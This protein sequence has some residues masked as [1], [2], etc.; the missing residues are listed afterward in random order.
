MVS[1]C[2]VGDTCVKG[3]VNAIRLD[4]SGVI[5]KHFLE[6]SIPGSVICR[7]CAGTGVD[8]KAVFNRVCRLCAG[9]GFYRNKTCKSCHCLYSVEGPWH[10]PTCIH[11]AP[12]QVTWSVLAHEDCCDACGAKPC[13]VGPHHDTRCFRHLG[14]LPVVLP[15][16][17]LDMPYRNC[18]SCYA[19]PI[20]NGPWH[21]KDCPK[22][23]T[24]TDT[25]L[26]EKQGDWSAC[27]FCPA[28][29]NVPG[30]HHANHDQNRCP[31]FVPISCPECLAKPPAS[32]PHHVQS[33][34]S[35]CGTLPLVSSESL[36]AMAFVNA[37]GACSAYPSFNGP[38]HA[39]DCPSRTTATDTGLLKQQGHYVDCKFCEA[40]PPVPGPH[41]AAMCCRFV[42]PASTPAPEPFPYAVEATPT[43]PPVPHTV[44]TVPGNA[45][46]NPDTVIAPQTPSSRRRPLRP[47]S[48]ALADKGTRDVADFLQ[49]LSLSQ[50][51]Y[52]TY[53]EALVS[54]GYDS[55]PALC[56]AGQSELLELK[57]K[58]PHVKLLLSK[59]PEVPN[60][61][62]EAR[63]R[64][65]ENPTFLKEPGPNFLNL[66]SSA[67]PSEENVIQQLR[68][69]ASV[70]GQC[71][72]CLDEFLEQKEKYKGDPDQFTKALLWLYSCDSWVYAD[73]NRACREDKKTILEY[74][75]PFVKA[76]LMGI[77][78][79]SG[80]LL[81]N[82]IPASSTTMTL[83][84]RANLTPN[85][86]AQY[87]QN[88]R[89]IWAGFTLTSLNDTNPDFGPQLFIIT[90]PPMFCYKVPLLESVSAFPEEEEALLPCNICF[91]V[92][93]NQPSTKP[94]TQV[95]ICMT[96]LYE[97]AVVW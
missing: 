94:G 37:C 42:D 72:F 24:A 77:P 33:C 46:A 59:L 8:K 96:M 66:I 82:T 17:L 56:L 49:K 61:E 95:E 88:V 4:K 25:G 16:L 26:L 14:D 7:K 6:A 30:P 67:N 80:L 36:L 54:A 2:F 28:V 48:R 76:L 40:R 60:G 81:G 71:T 68:Q 79:C 9:R 19:H 20:F 53:L 62:L 89:C 55:M 87:A 1:A 5:M 97:V 86:L 63:R 34:T 69:Y 57:L 23:T 3:C 73:G 18:S 58:G 13:M 45:P 11:F 39:K 29:P 10:V 35:H 74:M 75:M 15:K 52:T 51:V 78:K 84:R 31:R 12:C 22:M 90:V 50:N 21:A 93:S 43:M 38:W 70:T 85:Q 92:D 32:G 44:P 27:K 65:R 47:E 83:Y 91:K 64:R 41:H